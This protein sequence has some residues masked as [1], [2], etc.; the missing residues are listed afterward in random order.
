MGSTMKG[1]VV[2]SVSFN[3]IG[4]WVVVALAAIA[5]LVL[6]LWAYRQRLHG[7]SGRWRWIALGL[8]LLAVLLCILATLRPSVVLLEKVKQA[9]TLIFA[10]DGTTSMMITD[11]VGGKSRYDVAK[12][13]LELGREAVKKLGPGI[14]AKF[15]RFDSRAHEIKSAEVGTADGKQTAL[16]SVLMEVVKLQNE[17]RVASIVLITDA[18]SNAGLAPL[19]AAQHLASQGVP[20][21]GVGVGSETAGAASRDIAARTLDA[22]PTVFVK[23]ELQVRGTLNVRGYANKP[24]KVKLFVE[25]QSGPVAETTLK[26]PEGTEVVPVRGLKY[27]PQTPGE[28]LITLKVDPEE[29]ELVASN[30]EISTFITVLKGGLNVLFLQGPNFSWEPK[31]LGWNLAA[32]RDIH[33]EFVG[34]RVSAREDPGVISDSEFAPGRYD[35]YVFADLPAEFLTLRQHKLLVSAIEKGAGLLMLGGRASFGAGRW[36]NTPVGDILPVRIHPGDG[37]SDPESGIKVV[38]VTSALDNYVLR[39]GPTREESKRIWSTL[40]PIPG[41]NRFTGPKEGAIILAETPEREPLMVAE[42]G[43]GQ[44]RVLAFGGETWVWYRASH[45][46]QVAHRKFWRQA[47]LWLASKENQ[48]E[49]QVK[50]ALNTRRVS[51]GDKLQITA[52]ARDAKNDP[53]TDAQWDAKVVRTGPDE[54]PESRDL[55][56]QGDEAHGFYQATGAPG[57]Y[58]VTVSATHNGK[59]IGEDTA[60]FLVYQDDRELENPAADHALLR[61]IAE[62][63]SGKFLTPEQLGKYLKGLDSKDFTDYVTQKEHKIWD[64]WF[65]L[66]LF[67]AVLTLEWW[68]RKKNGWV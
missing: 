19:S 59:P 26:A 64:N 31:Y 62:I 58:R 39:L 61:Q 53:I 52:I 37:Q 10:I 17:N 47:I 50:I 63:T 43:P 46:S 3:P 32:S 16:G 55:F 23:N 56:N 34:L 24:L 60:R 45:E 29:G 27:M 9:S 30:N 41:A 22:G 2:R 21:I 40:A 65:F 11:E 25:G 35:V 14:D 36:A 54:K 5:V 8:R 68:L 18:A 15:Y 42:K 6:T 20:V 51:V 7:T 33:V 38:P 44:G 4:P 57:E 1:A 49:S 12:H 28:K 48:G 67:V 13:G 66:I